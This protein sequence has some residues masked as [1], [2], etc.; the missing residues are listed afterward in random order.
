MHN[1]QTAGDAGNVDSIDHISSLFTVSS[2]KQS[3]FFNFQSNLLRTGFFVK[4]SPVL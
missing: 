3:M 1:R 4:G 2:S